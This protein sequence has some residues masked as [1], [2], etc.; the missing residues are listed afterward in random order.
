MINEERKKNRPCAL[1]MKG[2]GNAEFPRKKNA[3]SPTPSIDPDPQ[4]GKNSLRAI[5]GHTQY[6]YSIIYL[7]NIK[8]APPGIPPTV[9]EE[10]IVLPSSK[11]PQFIDILI[12]L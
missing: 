4:K 7:Y 5:D 8:A 6:I 9:S 12:F 11:I 10:K 3:N 1:P 2:G